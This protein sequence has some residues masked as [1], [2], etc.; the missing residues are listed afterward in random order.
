MATAVS[1]P[2]SVSSGNDH[3][4]GADSNPVLRKVGAEGLLQPVD[5]REEAVG[6]SGDGHADERGEHQHSRVGGAP[7]Q[8]LG[9]GR[10]PPLRMRTR[11]AEP[12]QGVI[13]IG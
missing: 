9:I 10:R 1:R 11:G 12:P 4:A 3:L 5:Q 2:A 6:G 8:Y 7:E 13:W